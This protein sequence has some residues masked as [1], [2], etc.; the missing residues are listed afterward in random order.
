[1][2]VLLTYGPSS[3]HP[4][5]SRLHF[6]Q[7]F[8]LWS[9]KGVSERFYNPCLY[10]SRAQTQIS[11]LEAKITFHL[12]TNNFTLKHLNWATIPCDSDNYNVQTFHCRVYVILSL[13]RMSQM[14]TELTSY[15][16]ST[17]AYVQLVRW[18][19]YS[20]FPPTFWCSHNLYVKQGVF[21]CH[22]SRVERGKRGE[23]VFMTVINLPPGQRHDTLDLHAW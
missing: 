22:I 7:G 23:E 14:T 9:E 3:S 12:F 15:S 4:R 16:L 11:N 8:M 19:E 1:M 13:M 20:S 6:R 17:T 5:N 10:L 18:P 2:I 21:K